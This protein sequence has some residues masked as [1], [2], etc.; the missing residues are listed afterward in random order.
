MKIKLFT[1][2]VKKKLLK[3]LLNQ[4]GRHLSLMWNHFRWSSL[5]IFFFNYKKQTKKKNSIK[6]KNIIVPVVINH[7]SHS[8]LF[9][10]N[11]FAH[12]FLCHCFSL[13]FYNERKMSRQLIDLQVDKSKYFSFE[14]NFFFFRAQWLLLLNSL[15]N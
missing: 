15:W 5:Y 7:P 9:E 10:P 4:V 8:F 1:R 11:E 3:W 2:T 6:L 14:F 12:L 13:N